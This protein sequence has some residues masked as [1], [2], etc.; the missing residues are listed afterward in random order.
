MQKENVKEKNICKKLIFT[1][2]KSDFKF[3][4]KKVKGLCAFL[5]QSSLLNS[6]QSSI[7]SSALPVL[8]AT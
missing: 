2:S 7:L 6:T 3:V 8:Y 5:Q 4:K 1:I